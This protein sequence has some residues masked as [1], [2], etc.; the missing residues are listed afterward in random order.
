MLLGLERVATKG[1][2]VTIYTRREVRSPFK[3]RDGYA[4]VSVERPTQRLRVT[5]KFAR[6]GAPAQAR[7]VTAPSGDENE[8]ARYRYGA[9]GRPYFRASFRRPTPFKMYSFRWQW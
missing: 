8:V 3:G 7:L 1:E 9:D 4:E 6:R 2:V 5:V